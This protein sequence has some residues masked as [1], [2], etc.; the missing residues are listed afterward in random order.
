[1]YFNKFDIETNNSQSENITTLESSVCT[2]N[3]PWLSFKFDYE[4][5]PYF[6]K[7][8]NNT[9]EIVPVIKGRNS[10]VPVIFGIISEGNASIVSVKMRMHYAV[11]SI[12][13]FMITVVFFTMIEEGLNIGLV[14]LILFLIWTIME[15]LEQYKICKNELQKLFI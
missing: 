13:L 14:I 10:F 9:F 1:M 15:Y 7:I 8:N 6:G 3:L 4:N 5:K 11:I 2:K 12:L